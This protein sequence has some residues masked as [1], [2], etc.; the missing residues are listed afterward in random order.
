MAEMERLSDATRAEIEELLR[1][2]RTIEAVKRYREDTG[3]DL[4]EA[5]AAV[6]GMAAAVPGEVQGGGKPIGPRWGCLGVLVVAAVAGSLLAS[7]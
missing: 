7:I 4:D 5:K 1:Q 6:E 3:A 2:G